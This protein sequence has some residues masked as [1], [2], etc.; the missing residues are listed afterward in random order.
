MTL[1]ESFRDI[2][3]PRRKQGQ[4][5]NLEQLLSMIVISYLCGK[6]G[7]RKIARF[8][9]INKAT[10]ISELNLKHGIPSHVTFRD[11][12]TR[13]PD[14]QMVDAFNKWTSSNIRLNKKTWISGDGKALGSTVSDSQGKNQ[15][16][17]AIVSFFCQESGLTYSI[18]Q[19]RNKSKEIGEMNV[20]RFLIEELKYKGVIIRLDAL[21][22][23][24]EQ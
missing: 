1:F 22:T 6:T 21:H 11:I 14:T 16:F 12:L 13:I 8:C 23:Q 2:E 7:Y 17:Q 18:A 5:L 24:K 15:D 3:D 20:A 19:Y 4:R 10:F 9:R